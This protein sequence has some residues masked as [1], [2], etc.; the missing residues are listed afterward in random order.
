MVAL[1][2]V[3]A[4][5][6]QWNG[7]AMR[8]SRQ[9][10]TGEFILSLF[11]MGYAFSAALANSP[12][13]TVL[14]QR[15]GLRG[16]MAW[17]LIMGIPACWLALLDFYEW[18]LPTTNGCAYARSLLLIYQGAAWAYA[19]HL[20]LV[21]GRP[22]SLLFMHALIGVSACAWFHIENRRVCREIRAT[23]AN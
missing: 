14:L 20:M 7:D 8:P 16:V 21:I 15:E 13:H 2:V 11:A 4:A 23:I 9:M 5:R 1:R 3:A 18:L 17:L 12:L 22:I 6:G 19:M 10:L